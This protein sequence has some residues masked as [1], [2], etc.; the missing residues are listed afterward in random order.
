MLSIDTFQLGNIVLEFLLKCD[1]IGYFLPNLA[2]PSIDGQ[3]Y[4]S[5]HGIEITLGY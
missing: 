2:R 5:I 3:I 4:T 1:N